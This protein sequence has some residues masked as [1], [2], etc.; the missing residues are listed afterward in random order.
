VDIN[1]NEQIFGFDVDKTLVSARRSHK[2]RDDIPVHN[3]YTNETVFVK[4]H[5]GHIDLLKEM[6]GRGRFVRVWSA[7]GVK[8]AVAVVQ[9][10]KIEQWVD[11]VETK[12][13]G[14]V[15]DKPASEWLSNII[16]LDEDERT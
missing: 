14:I 3:P 4:P 6:K 16:Y 13:L 12:P 5:V 7:A 9:A 15:D 10:L 1:Y 2:G 8:W 11:S